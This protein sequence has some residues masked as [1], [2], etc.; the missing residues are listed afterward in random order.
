ML[1]VNWIS[2]IRKKGETEKD[3]KRFTRRLMDNILW[4]LKSSS[5]FQQC[6][7]TAITIRFLKQE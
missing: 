3:K 6:I 7:K 2:I 5:E 4:N 1:H